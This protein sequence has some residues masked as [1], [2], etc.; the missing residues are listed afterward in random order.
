MASDLTLSARPQ[1]QGYAFKVITELKGLDTLDGLVYPS[2]AEQ[3]ELL[4]AVLLAQDKDGEI[5]VEADQFATG[6]G[7]AGRAG[8]VSNGGGGKKRADGAPAA[9]RI[10]GSLNALSGATTMSCTSTPLGIL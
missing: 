5:G 6:T 1:D 9:K 7:K 10:A 3:L 2:R 4:Q 8:V